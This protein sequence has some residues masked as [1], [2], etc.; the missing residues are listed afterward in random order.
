MMENQ[1]CRCESLGFN[2]TEHQSRARSPGIPDRFHKATK[3]LN[4]VGF[5]EKILGSQI[6]SLYLC[7][8]PLP[9]N[10]AQSYSSDFPHSEWRTSVKH[11]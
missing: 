7:L 4:R 6:Y 1:C 8:S 11:S 2:R 10:L 5:S 9:L 3:R